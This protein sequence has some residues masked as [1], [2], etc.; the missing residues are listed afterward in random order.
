[1][2]NLDLG[3]EVA[4]RGDYAE[5][6]IHARLDAGLPVFFYLWSPHPLTTRYDPNRIQLPRYTPPLFESGRSDYPIDVLEKVASAKLAALA[7]DVA[8]LYSNFHLSNFAQESMLLALQSDDSS[9]MLATCAWMRNEENSADVQAWFELLSCE[10]SAVT[11]EGLLGPLAGLE[12][13]VGTVLS[14]SPIRVELTAYTVG[15]EPMK[16]THADVEIRFGGHVL[17]VEW[18]QGSNRYIADVSAD[19]TEKEGEYELVVHALNG[20]RKSSKQAR[21]C[22]LFRCIVRVDQQSRISTTWLLVGAAFAGVVFVGILVVV[23]RRSHAHLKAIMTMLFTE[24]SELVLALFIESADVCTSCISCRRVLSGAIAVPSEAYK[25][26]YVTVLCFG[27]V[28]TTISFAYR[29]R[30]ARLVKA[31]MQKLSASSSSPGR[32]FR[33]R[34][35]EVSQQAQRFEWEL[36]QTGRTMVIL[37]LA[38]MSV[39]L[40]GPHGL[41]GIFAPCW[42]SNPSEIAVGALQVCP[43]LS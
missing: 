41:F 7:P 6:V 9:V 25:A 24:T 43:C 18:S 15:N 12:G 36:L 39:L 42:H 4:Y 5:D 27:V 40:Q 37:G 26:G 16:R 23:V 2:T 20:W 21:S 13:D 14:S 11:V 38:L 1:M 17:P 35:S 31:H 28:G 30:N 29:F 19:L 8:E 10:D 33:S 34:G 22:T 32:S 3:Y